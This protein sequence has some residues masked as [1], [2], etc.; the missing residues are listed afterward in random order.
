M[1]A[2]TRKSSILI[3]GDDVHLVTLL[4]NI[5]A[6]A[7][8]DLHHAK[9]IDEV[10]TIA[11]QNYFD[12]ALVDLRVWNHDEQIVLEKLR[13]TIAFGA[14]P[15]IALIDAD[16]TPKGTGGAAGFVHLPVKTNEL[17]TSVAE[18]LSRLQG[19]RL[20]L[21]QPPPDTEY[22]RSDDVRQLL[23]R[24]LLEQKTL[25][26]IGRTLNITLDIN[27]VLSKVVDA[28]MVLTRAEESLLLLP[29]DDDQT[30]YVQAEKGLD[31][32]T[33]RHFRI[34]TKD[35]LA[36]KVYKTG[37]PLLIAHAGWLKIKTAYYVQ[38]LLYVPLK[39]QEDVIGVLGVNNR[40]TDRTF[41]EHD[42][43]LLEDLASHAAIAI[44]NARLYSEMVNRSK[45]L[46]TLFRVNEVVNSTLALDEVLRLIAEQM[47]QALNVDWCEIALFDEDNHYLNVLASYR[48]VFWAYALRP[49][50]D[51]D[52][53]FDTV[54]LTGQPLRTVGK[55]LYYPSD[56]WLLPLLE[57][58][59]LELRYLEGAPRTVPTL[60][61][62]S[63]L[64]TALANADVEMRFRVKR[65]VQRII[66]ESG[67]DI[68]H[69][70]QRQEQGWSQKVNIGCGIWLKDPMPILPPDLF[71]ELHQLR[72]IFTPYLVT[73]QEDPSRLIERF[74]ARSV[75]AL[76]LIISGSPL[77]VVV[78]A[79]TLHL[80]QFNE[81][82]IA[83]AQGLVLQAGNALQNARLFHDLQL[84]LNELRRTQIKLVQSARMSAI[85]ELAAAIAHQINNPLTTILGD[86]ELLLTDHQE[87]DRDW[88]SLQAIYRAG[89]RA[90]EVVH[91]LLGMAY[92]VTDDDVPDL[93]DVNT[94]INNT[95]TLVGAH[96]RHHMIDLQINLA[97]QLPPAYGLRGQLE[98]VWLN[99]LLNARDA[100]K[101]QPD[102]AIGIESYLQDDKVMVV[103]WDNGPG[104]TPDNQE[105]VFEAFFTTKSRGEGT[106]LGLHICR[107]IVDKCGGLITIQTNEPRGT[108]M[109]VSLQVDRN[110]AHER[111]DSYIGGG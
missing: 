50:R 8:Y 80:H 23:A 36:G 98:D 4:Q 17:L 14:F 73:S 109:I 108:Q 66:R 9:A 24:N 96:I 45:E 85:G 60:Y 29:D 21:D 101:D 110:E 32:E 84:S 57:D 46:S 102:P 10:G 83:L 105:R 39:I 5:L 61:D 12:L 37:E 52:L 56:A 63:E 111:R 49:R 67:A 41:T 42:Q 35:S 93:M 40:T 15:W 88:E 11:E 69:V 1:K 58:S 59:V 38:S 75:L 18:T 106:G 6:G 27:E 30:L 31:S 97:E 90:Y 78:L 25:S 95:L 89:R 64:R 33:V 51:S 13:E 16:F 82:E 87:G 7:G 103:V 100:V 44:E 68:A 70:W 47:T 26:D 20:T 55:S 53:D 104:I 28:A 54:I 65:L 43:T 22:I 48:Q 81:R 71:P 92:Q 72:H 99:L 79:D 62:L 77:G 34:R 91:R 94:T 107:Q 3:V 74:S 86:T 76:P 19:S 2:R